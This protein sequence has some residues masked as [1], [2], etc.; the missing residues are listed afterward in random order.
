MNLLNRVYVLIYSVFCAVYQGG[1]FGLS[2]MMPPRYTQALMTGQGIGGIFACVADIGSKLGTSDPLHSAFWYFLTAVVVLVVCLIS[3][4][5]LYRIV[6]YNVPGLLAK[7]H[8]C[9]N[10]SSP[11]DQ[12]F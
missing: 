6:S 1:L 3:Y 9:I 4:L 10:E 11:V 2:G 12:P 8:L 7:T 5:G